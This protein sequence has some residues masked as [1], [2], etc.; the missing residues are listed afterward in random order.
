MNV[1]TFFE[2]RD[3]YDKYQ[4]CEKVMEYLSDEES[5]KG[6]KYL[7]T[8]KQFADAF[9]MEFMMFVH[10][11]MEAVGMAFEAVHCPEHSEQPDTPTPP[12]EEKDPKFPIGSKVEIVEG[13][14]TGHV[15]TVMEYEP[16]VEQMTY[17]VSS[18]FNDNGTL[19]SM[20]FLEPELKAYVEESEEKPE[21]G[22]DEKTEEPPITDA[23]GFYVG[24]RVKVTVEPYVGKIGTVVGFD[25]N[26][27]TIAV[28]LDDDD[29]ETYSFASDEL[30]KIDPE[31]PEEN[32]GTAAP[33]EGE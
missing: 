21:D 2:A 19:F 7:E 28:I 22:E 18:D 27:N 32:G 3:L 16:E 9:K 33:D 30:E 24:D 8:L 26:D 12:T 13:V 4:L 6:Q 20:W 15:G 29:E 31:N 1:E 23:N 5:V 25:E 10:E 14:F 17:Y 11:R